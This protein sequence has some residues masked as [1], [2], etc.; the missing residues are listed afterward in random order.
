MQ[1]EEIERA[2]RNV[3]SLG[4]RVKLGAN[5]R[6][7]RGNY[8]GTPYQQVEDLHAMFRD[9]EVK[10]VWSGRG[11]SGCAL[12]LPL[13]DY[14]LILRANPK[15]FVGFSDTTALHLGILRHARIVTF[16]GPAGHHRRSRPIRSSTCAPRFMDPR[17]DIRDRAESGIRRADDSSRA[18]PPGLWSAGTSRC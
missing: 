10:A 2:V 11:G 5:I 8:A 4:L 14:G 3:E 18:S 17:R 12:L 16:H 6:L 7:Q 13:L 15:V 9:R 1:D